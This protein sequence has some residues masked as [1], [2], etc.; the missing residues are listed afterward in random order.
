MMPISGPGTFEVKAGDTHE[1]TIYKLA[2][3]LIHG[4]QN[5]TVYVF[6]PSM[7]ST[8][9]INGDVNAFCSEVYI[10]GTV[11]NNVLAGAGVVVIAGT[12][13]GDVS[14]YGGR[15]TLT[16]QAH[17]MGDVKMAGGQAVLLG[18]VDGDIDVQA[19]MVNADAAVLGD[20]KIR[21]DKLDFGPNWKLKG[22]LDSQSR[23]SKDEESTAGT[24][25]PDEHPGAPETVAST[26]SHDES[27]LS[28]KHIWFFLAHLLVGLVV[29]ALFRNTCATAVGLIRTDALRVTTIGFVGLVVIPVGTVILT[30]LT[31]F[32]ILPILLGATVLFAYLAIL[33]FFAKLPVAAWLGERAFGVIGWT[34][35]SPFKTFP[36]GLVILYLAFAIPKLWVVF[37]LVSAIVGFGAIVTVL[38]DRIQSHRS[39]KIGRPLP[40]V[41]PPLPPEP[42]A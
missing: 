16:D 12:V 20:A 19:G 1:G 28:R 29:L 6:G 39:R 15:L 10:G 31:C 26:S 27:R 38:W 11:A 5:G 23:E 25:A 35:S 32:L 42:A 41:L 22:E 14:I 3:V 21:S 37:W 36:V 8:G 24:A 17:V 4:T 30:I 9:T 2:P 34:D 13:H 7:Y 18:K 33:F 40:G